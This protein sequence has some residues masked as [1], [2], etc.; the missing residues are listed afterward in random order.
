MIS[1]I[2]IQ[3]QG[4]SRMKTRSVFG[5]IAMLALILGAFVLRP[6]PQVNADGLTILK[7]GT[8]IGIPRVYS[9]TDLLARGVIGAGAPWAIAGAEGKLT[10]SGKLDIE[11][12]GLV[13][14][15]NDPAL[16]AAGRAGI[17]PSATFRAVVSCKT[18]DGGVMNVT[19]DP[20]PATTG[21]ASAG[22]GDAHIEAKLILPRPCIAPIVFIT[23]PAGTWFAATGY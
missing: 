6:A 13:L 15:P 8:M 3:P 1:N 10:A 2:H 20:F 14:D 5:L 7:F 19:T 4:V 16:I 23:S 9:G 17:N 21:P 12:T 18:G 22:G 11:V